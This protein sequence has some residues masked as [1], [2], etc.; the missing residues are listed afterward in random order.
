MY[1]LLLYILASK[2][3]NFANESSL[4]YFYIFVF[5]NFYIYY[6]NYLYIN[7]LSYI[8]IYMTVKHA[9]CNNNGKKYT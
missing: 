7:E 1:I 4:F 8:Y 2:Y 9:R 3:K 5:Y 6:I